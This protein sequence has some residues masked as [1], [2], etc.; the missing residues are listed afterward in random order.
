MGQKQAYENNMALYV[1]VKSSGKKKEHDWIIDCQPEQETQRQ[2]DTFENIHSLC[3]NYPQHRNV[4][5][6]VSVFRTS[7]STSSS[8]A[9]H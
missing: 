9:K 4:F 8:T 5:T 3:S 7:V 6:V 2:A 1:R